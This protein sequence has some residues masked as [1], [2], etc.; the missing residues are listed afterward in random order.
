MNKIRVNLAWVG[1]I[2]LILG[3]FAAIPSLHKALSHDHDLYYDWVEYIQVDRLPA[4]ST[5][6]DR[7]MGGSYHIAVFT[8]VRFS[9]VKGHEIGDNN[10]YADKDTEYDD[11][12]IID[13]PDQVEYKVW[14]SKDGT[15]QDWTN[16]ESSSSE[17][18]FH[19]ELRTQNTPASEYLKVT[20][21]DLEPHYSPGT[22][23]DPSDYESDSYTV[24]WV[25]P[26]SE[27]SEHRECDQ[28]NGW[29]QS[30]HFDTYRM[31]LSES[32]NVSF[33]NLWIHEVLEEVSDSC[34]LTDG[35]DTAT[36]Q[37]N[38]NN[39]Y[40]DE[41]GKRGSTWDD[42]SGCTLQAKQTIYLRRT[43]NDQA[44]QIKLY[45]N[46][47]NWKF[48]PGGGWEDFI[49]QRVTGGNTAQCPDW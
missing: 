25:A 12:A 18:G 38:Q 47:L 14:S 23:N 33:N 41:L 36:A 31:T 19:E 24:T 4:V 43:E 2:L 35:F 9:W 21:S 48:S 22:T 32:H 29:L 28:N 3:I 16:D 8:Q 30:H 11:G 42:N 7:G 15:I 5:N 45:E 27:T 17:H 37:I 20:V 44:S 40:D 10:Y 39:Q 1:E 26:S 49:S 46:T 13:I 34:D 6:P